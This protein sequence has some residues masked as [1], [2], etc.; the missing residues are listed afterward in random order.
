[1]STAPVRVGIALCSDLDG[2]GRLDLGV[3]AQELAELEPD[4]YIEVV[5]DLCHGPDHAPAVASRAGAERVVLGVCA[6]PPAA[7]DFQARARKAGLDPFALEFVEL[8]GAHGADTSARVIAAAVARL[9]AF[10]GSR[11][12][13]L[14]LRLLSFEQQR[15]RRSLF[16]LPPSTYEPV[17]SVERGSC[18]GD[19][20]CGLCLS[21]CPFAAIAPA[22]GKAAVD[23]DACQSCGVCVTVCPTGAIR[24]PGAS[25]PQYEAEISVLLAAEAPRI[26]FR[27]RGA[28]HETDGSGSLAAGWL[29]VEVPCL[30]MVTPG[31]IL[32]ALAGRAAS[33]ALLSCGD[34]CRS[35][36][37]TQ[38]R[39]RVDYCREVL[40]LLGESSPSERVL[41]GP[42]PAAVGAEPPIGAHP[43]VGCR[44]TLREPTATAEGLLALQERYCSTSTPSLSHA[45][46][47]LGLITLEEETCTACGACPTSCP[48]GALAI[49]ET[50]AAT[51]ISY[52]AALCVSCGRCVSACP[53]AAHDTLKFRAGTDL[54][55]LASGRV[56]LK[57]SSSA[58]CHQCGRPVAPEDMLTRIRALLQDDAGGEPLLDV[59]TGLCVD[60][61]GLASEPMSTRPPVA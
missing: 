14:K 9:R 53:E 6:R 59:L 36:R 52:E 10:S 32:Q 48:T 8:N 3:L 35:G 60:C 44:V 20:R 15:S 50:T 40:G 56:I 24:L 25:L 38:V 26:L 4:V 23:R 13:Q 30:G 42:L 2:T 37:A 33:V 43:P 27:C 39:E 31:W 46:S 57:R 49:E 22:G 5:P 29:P 21:A 55:A 34:V 41:F 19:E 45:G 1:M 17:A 28:M 54:A 61:R 51:I 11:P 7:H 16:T 58:R 18:L 47:P 12:E